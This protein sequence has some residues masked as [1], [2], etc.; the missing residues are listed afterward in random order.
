MLPN[1]LSYHGRSL[2]VVYKES[3]ITIFT[4]KKYRIKEAVQNMNSKPVIIWSAQYLLFSYERGGQRCCFRWNLGIFKWVW[5][6]RN[7]YS[8][9]KWYSY[10]QIVE[11]NYSALF[12]VR[13]YG[14]F[15]LSYI[16]ELF[17][18]ACIQGANKFTKCQYYPTEF[19]KA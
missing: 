10:S 1:L 14:R 7:S 11:P 6:V 2:F 19:R 18:S 4:R 15:S 3:V 8:Y 5:I 13:A 12:D 9:F 16:P 17:Q